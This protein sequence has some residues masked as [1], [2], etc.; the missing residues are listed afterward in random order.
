[1]P[2]SARPVASFGPTTL[3]SV[4][5]RSWSSRSVMP[6]GTGVDPALLDA[7]EVR[8]ERLVPLVQLD[9]HVRVRAFDVLLD[10][11]SVGGAGLGAGDQRHELAVVVDERV[12]ERDDRVDRG[13]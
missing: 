8:V 4:T 11:R 12:E 6:L 13:L 2:I 5:R 10:A 3:S 9:L 7:D 1:M